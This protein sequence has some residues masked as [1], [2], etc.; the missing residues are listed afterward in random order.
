SKTEEAGEESKA[1]DAYNEEL[2]LFR[3]N[4]NWNN[5]NWH[6]LFCLSKRRTKMHW[7]FTTAF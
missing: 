5:S 7:L 4:D 6:F 3:K 1:E 2:S